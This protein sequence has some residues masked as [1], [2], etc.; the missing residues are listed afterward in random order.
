MKNKFY[1]SLFIGIGLTVVA[2]PS[3][4]K[5]AQP[6]VKK[7]PSSSA[8]PAKA[9]AHIVSSKKPESQAP[10]KAVANTVAKQKPS[11]AKTQHPSDTKDSKHSKTKAQQPADAK[12]SKH[13][14][15]KAQQPADAKDSKHSKSKAQQLAEAKEAKHGTTKA[16]QLAEA[17][18]AK[19]GKSKA[20]QLSEAKESKHGKS[21][22]HSTSSGSYGDEEGDAS[23]AV[24]E[25]DGQPI[26]NNN[27]SV[28]SSVTNQP[29]SDNIPSNNT[30]GK[31][32]VEDII[33]PTQ[34]DNLFFSPQPLVTSP[35]ELT[36]KDPSPPAS[37]PFIAT[38]TTSANQANQAI[39]NN[40]VHSL[41]N[42]GDK[43]Y[44]TIERVDD[45]EETPL[46][47][48]SETNT[49]FTPSSNNN[50]R[51]RSSVAPRNN[52][53]IDNAANSETT[54]QVAS[55]HG[56]IDASLTE[57]GKKAGLSG[58]MVIQLA[59][60]FAWDIDFANNLQEGDQFTMVY[61]EAGIGN[62]GDSHQIIAAEFIN[63]GKKYTAIR[64]KDKEGVTGYYTPDGRST[65][66]AFLT[67]PIDFARVSSHFD[68]HRKHPI[69]NRIRA[70]KGVDYAA[71]TGT[72][73]K[74]AGD[75][76]I[77]SHENRGA[78]GRMIVIAHGEHYETA[79]AH[80]SNFREGLQDGE[81]VKQGDVI[82]YVGQSGLATGP[83]LHYEFR[84]DGEHRDPEKLDSKQAMRLPNGIWE[85]FHSKTVPVLTQLNQAKVSTVAR[86]NQ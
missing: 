18:E 46:P 64:Y 32:N 77:R 85:D 20:Q 51:I 84:V 83:H 10:K 29:N 17:K 13:S 78:Y 76:V 65:R 47:A 68:P 58:E 55:A 37:N 53:F 25:T 15:S 3:F 66:K 5:A 57:S 14:K 4:A 28:D 12:D 19:H 7:Q 82:G 26:M 59:D 62:T 30:Y 49:L 44:Q 23:T 75:G 71:R 63:R 73:V 22:S 81:P 2:T 40:R 41:I 69:L 24:E 27:E 35:P 6:T 72:P 34:S 36:N 9:N 56:T 74:A 67:T 33:A 38:P 8:K 60:V 31:G 16:Q 54:H 42:K 21:K 80:L 61:E 50:K 43:P 70:H 45:T 52:N 48:P 39:A 79:Y 86:Q 11:Q 1:V